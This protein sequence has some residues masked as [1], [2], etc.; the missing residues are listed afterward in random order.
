MR[1]CFLLE[2]A[3]APL[4]VLKVDVNKITLA[5]SLPGYNAARAFLTF[6]Q[7]DSSF[8]RRVEVEASLTNRSALWV[9]VVEEKYGLSDPAVDSLNFQ[10]GLDAD[11]FAAGIKKVVRNDSSTRGGVAEFIDGSASA[12]DS[13]CHW[14]NKG[15]YSVRCAYSKV[16]SSFSLL[17]TGVE[18]HAQD[19]LLGG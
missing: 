12:T 1:Y 4:F 9:K 15:T 18:S 17:G 2:N 10:L 6:Q 7:P 19:L 13:C 16:S 5:W 3:N 11:W 14:D 8:A